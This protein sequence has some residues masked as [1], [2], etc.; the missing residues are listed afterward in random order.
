[1]MDLFDFTEIQTGQSR[2]QA[3]FFHWLNV[4]VNGVVV[5]NLMR[6]KYWSGMFENE[7]WTDVDRRYFQLAFL[8]GK[9]SHSIEMIHNLTDISEEDLLHL[10]EFMGGFNDIKTS[11]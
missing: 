9:N 5:I 11:I 8:M 7:D 6:N 4:G 10:L 2:L 3:D 1:M